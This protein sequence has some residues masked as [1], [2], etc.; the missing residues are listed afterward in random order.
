MLSVYI[1]EGPFSFKF[2]YFILSC[3]I[4]EVDQYLTLLKNL[5]FSQFQFGTYTFLPALYF[6]ACFP[7]MK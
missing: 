2:Y 6:K 7:I 4:F 3:W 5:K 1:V